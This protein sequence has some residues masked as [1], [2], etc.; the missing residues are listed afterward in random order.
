MLKNSAVNQTIKS[1]C[2]KTFNDFISV[3]KINQGYYGF[4]FLIEKSKEPKR[5]IAKVYKTESIMPKEH[6]QLDLLRKYALT[7][8]P[9]I[10]SESLKAENGVCDIM[11]M[12][13]IN[14]VNGSQIKN[15]SAREKSILAEEI[16]NNLIAIHSVKNPDGFGEIDGEVFSA[17]WNEYYKMTVQNRVNIL[18]KKAGFFFPKKIVRAADMLLENFDKVFTDEINDACLIHGDY[19]MWNLMVN[20]DT[21]RLSGMIDPMGCSFSDRELDLFQLE[22][23]NG[24]DFGLLECYIKKSGVSGNI[25][26]KNGYY[27][28]FDDIKHW[29]LSGNLDKLHTMK[30]LSYVTF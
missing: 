5:V 19:N 3:K 30:Y 25:V 24:K 23:A 22:N 18:H 9:E 21:N 26:S 7:K 17:S 14:G 13:Y 8:V 27:G 6:A 29:I 11:L 4:V 12:E 15:I 1:L 16:T 2:E 20:P 28:F 10:Y